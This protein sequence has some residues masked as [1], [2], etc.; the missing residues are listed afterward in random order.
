[1]NQS[2]KGLG[3]FLERY[4]HVY[5][6][7]AEFYSKWPYDYLIDDTHLAD[8]MIVKRAFYPKLQTAGYLKE[9]LDYFEFGVWE[10]KTFA[11]M[12]SLL[13]SEDCRLFGFDT[14]QGLPE[15]MWIKSNIA[16]RVRE[17][18]MH[19]ITPHDSG[20]VVD[21]R[22][23]F[24][25]GLFQQTLGD[26]LK[27]Y[28]NRR[29]FINIDSDLYSSALYILASFHPFLMTGD[30]LLFDEFTH[31][32]HEYSAYNDYIRSFYMKDRLQLIARN[33]NQYVFSIV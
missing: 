31:E 5:D 22:A 23:R 19:A 13:K 21:P 26:F 20:V 33:F 29:K 12:S 2:W 28:R 18:D 3:E 14:F 7:A 10:G 15:D 9:P 17:F 11:V 32:E 16:L 30:V 6:S 4:G 25:S 27:T 8:R 24:I 1:M